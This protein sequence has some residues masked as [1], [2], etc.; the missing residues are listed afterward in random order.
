M[1]WTTKDIPD[2]RGRP[3][4]QATAAPGELR[5]LGEPVYEIKGT[6]AEIEA[7]IAVLKARR[8]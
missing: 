2:P 3:V 8:G 5:D 6:L 4:E 7:F 1:G